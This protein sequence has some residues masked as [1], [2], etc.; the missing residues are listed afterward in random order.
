MIKK[1]QVKRLTCYIMLILILSVVQGKAQSENKGGLSYG[2]KAGLNLSALSSN[3]I[4]LP[5]MKLG[6]QF[7]GFGAYSLMPSLSVELDVFYAKMGSSTIDPAKIYVSGTPGANT[8]VKSSVRMNTLEIPVLAKYSFDLSGTKAYL[9]IGPEM[10]FLLSVK[11]V[12]TR[13]ESTGET[14]SKADVTGSFR[15]SDFAGVIGFGIELQKELSVE[16]RYRSG[17]TSINYIRSRSY[18]D[19]CLNALSLNVGYSF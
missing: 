17:F 2:V 16:I 8:I 6:Y 5:D 12:N 7:G 18:S 15:G 4:G 11:A 10:S 1:Y 3:Y 13:I 14:I 9:I 19:F